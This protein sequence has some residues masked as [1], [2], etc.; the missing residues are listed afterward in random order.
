[1]DRIDVWSW[2]IGPGHDTDDWRLLSDDERVRADRF[3]HVRNRSRFIAARAGLRQRLAIYGDTRAEA[4]VFQ[5]GLCGK[6]ALDPPG[7]A[8]NL[9]HSGDRAALAVAACPVGLDIEEL[10]D[11]FAHLADSCFAP[12]E[13]AHLRALPEAERRCAFFRCWTRK[14]AYVKAL[15]CGLSLPLGRF[16]VSLDHATLVS[17]ADAPAE[18]GWWQMAHLDPAPGFVGAVA[19]RHRGWRVVYR[20]LQY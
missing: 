1:M 17:V 5:L 8:F 12:D 20:E 13:A 14:E 6:P 19:S 2:P 11:G 16:S 4:L 18:P 3:H 9:S 7:L 15:G 10:R